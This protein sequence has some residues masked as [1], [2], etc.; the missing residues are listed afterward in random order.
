M[1]DP[2]Q[3]VKAAVADAKAEVKS[4]IVT[5]RTSVREWMA[6]HPFEWGVVALGAGTALGIFAS[7]VVL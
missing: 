5:K 3:D 2:V 6:A 4:E 1:A 7:L